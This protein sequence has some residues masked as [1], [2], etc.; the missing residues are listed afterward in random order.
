[1]WEKAHPRRLFGRETI[2]DEF[3]EK[4]KASDLVLAMLYE[5]LGGGTKEAIEAVLKTTTPL[6]LLWFVNRTD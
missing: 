5:R 1:M 3:V 6:S 4:A 2:D